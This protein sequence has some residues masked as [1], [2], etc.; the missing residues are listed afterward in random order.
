MKI[1]KILLAILLISCLL[2]MPYGYF[3]FVRIISMICFAIFAYQY[4]SEKKMELAITFC[5][6]AILFQ[7]LIKIHLGRGL[8]NV[9]DVIVAVFLIFLLYLNKRHEQ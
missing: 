6:L 9:V 8:W 2:P 3:N 5:G 1:I 4:Y 7:P